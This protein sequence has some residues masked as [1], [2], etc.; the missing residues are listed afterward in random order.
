[1]AQP[2]V[3]VLGE[4]LSAVDGDQAHGGRLADSCSNR[5][6]AT[7]R[8]ADGLAMSSRN[9]YLTVE[10]RAKAPVVYQV[11]TQTAEALQAG[12]QDF[13]SL[14]E[15]AWNKLGKRRSATRLFSDP[16]GAGSA[17]PRQRRERFRS[18]QPPIL[19]PLALS[20]TK[21]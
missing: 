11:L 1:M 19:A 4:G 15:S 3:A 6:M 17:I 12:D 8:E 2:D 7:V 21:R 13:K 18:W 14:E 16:K 20:T 10:E 9:G 5:G